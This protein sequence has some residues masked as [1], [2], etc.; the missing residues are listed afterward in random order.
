MA[1][2]CGR[3]TVLLKLTTDGHEA[4]CGLTATVELLV[5]KLMQKMIALFCGT[6]YQLTDGLLSRIVQ[7]CGALEESI[8][9]HQRWDFLLNSFAAD[10][11][12]PNAGFLGVKI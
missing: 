8:P 11:L 2:Q 3:G 1:S 12:A 6:Q 5:C 7:G 10:F 4:P 9:V